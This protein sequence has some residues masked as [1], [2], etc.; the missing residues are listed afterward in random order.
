MGDE[1]PREISC[2]ERNKLSLITMCQGV[3]VNALFRKPLTVVE[4]EYDI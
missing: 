4:E 2:H 1:N 3:S